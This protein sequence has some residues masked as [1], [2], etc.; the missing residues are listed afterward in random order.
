MLAN[1][2]NQDAFADLLF[3]GNNIIAWAIVSANATCKESYDQHRGHGCQCS[4]PLGFEPR[5]PPLGRFLRQAR[6]NLLPYALSI[7][8]TRVWHGQRIECREY[9]FDS[10]QFR[11][12]LFANRQVPR[13][14]SPLGGHSFAVGS[15]LFFCHVF[16]DSVPIALACVPLPTKGCKARRNFCTARKTVFFA[17]P[18]LD[19]R[20]CAISSRSEEHTSELQSRLHLVCRLLLEK[21]KEAQHHALV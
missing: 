19:F 12:A 14:S 9:S 20:T 3:I 1:S 18:E 2:H 21:K 7:V 8:I 5:L 11:A 15:H 16:H 4:Q 13:H 6:G 10:F 17:A